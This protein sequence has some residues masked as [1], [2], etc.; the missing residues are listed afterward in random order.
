M[1]QDTRKEEDMAIDIYG[2]TWC[3]D[4][5]RAKEAFARFGVDYIWHDIEA[6]EDAADRAK[7]ISGQ[8]HI[9]VVVYDD[10]KFQVEPTALDIRT[11]LRELGVLAD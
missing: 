6:E 7:E 1:T 9:P 10:G 8:Q 3:G 5:K 11:K 4:C 2:A